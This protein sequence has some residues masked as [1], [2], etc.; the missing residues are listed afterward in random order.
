MRAGVPY[1]PGANTWDTWY[2][3]GYVITGDIALGL[4]VLRFD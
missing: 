2:H 3:P 1:N 4:D